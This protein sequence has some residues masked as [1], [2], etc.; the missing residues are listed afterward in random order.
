MTPPPPP[1]PP[2][3]TTNMG[4]FSSKDGHGPTGRATNFDLHKQL[5][6]LARLARTSVTCYGSRVAWIPLGNLTGAAGAPVSSSETQRVCEPCGVCVF[7]LRLGPLPASAPQRPSTV[8]KHA[9]ESNWQHL[10]I[11]LER[12]RTVVCLLLRWLLQSVGLQHLHTALGVTHPSCRD[13]TH[14][15]STSSRLLWLR[16]NYGYC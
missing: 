16:A 8:I 12:V 11:P 15:I 1:P 2:V 6:P 4:N 5:V 13:Q 7:S 9:R 14:N 10:V 3:T